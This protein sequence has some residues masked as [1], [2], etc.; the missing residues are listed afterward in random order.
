MTVNFAP[1]SCLRE[2]ETRQEVRAPA[3]RGVAGRVRTTAEWVA[4]FRA[5]AARRRP[6]PWQAGAEGPAGEPSAPARSLQARQLGGT[7]AGRPLR[8]AAARSRAPAG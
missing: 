1:T 3:G 8:R 7:L 4:Y 5:N 6:V 2:Q